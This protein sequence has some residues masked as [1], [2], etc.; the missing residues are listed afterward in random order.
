MPKTLEVFENEDAEKF[1]EYFS[2]Y[3]RFSTKADYIRQIIVSNVENIS[4]KSFP[5]L[6]ESETASQD[7][8]T[9][10]GLK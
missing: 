3:K 5:Q 4:S 10:L 7:Q 2:A 9:K 1:L 6:A 8:I